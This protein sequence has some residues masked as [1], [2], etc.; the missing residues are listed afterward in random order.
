VRF[1]GGGVPADLVAE[2]TD[3]KPGMVRLRTIA[4][5]TMI[6]QWLTWQGA[7]VN[8]AALDNNHTKIQWTLHYQ[9]RLS[10]AWYFGPWQR[11]AV[12]LSAGY[13]IDNLATPHD[14]P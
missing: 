2:I 6:S 5:N 7:E 12:E 13:L 3:Y 11:Y 10:P 1:V 9:R 4:D 8:W 14:I